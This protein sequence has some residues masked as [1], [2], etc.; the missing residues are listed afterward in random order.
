MTPYLY[1]I[2]YIMYTSARVAKPGQRRQVQGFL[3]DHGMWSY[4]AKTKKE[5][6]DRRARSK[7]IGSG[8]IPVGVRRFESGSSH[9]MDLIFLLLMIW[10]FVTFLYIC[11]WNI[12]KHYNEKTNFSAIF[13]NATLF[14]QVAGGTALA[15][16]GFGIIFMN[17]SLEDPIISGFTVFAMGI[18]VLTFAASETNQRALIKRIDDL[19]K[20]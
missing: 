9:Q 13:R 7:A 3:L 8:P 5:S 17:I 6:E 20:K 11:F 2:S 15:L 18:A 14:F 19:K 12:G 1:L 4:R 16:T 10:F